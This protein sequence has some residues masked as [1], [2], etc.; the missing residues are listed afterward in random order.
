[1][2]RLNP[3]TGDMDD[4]TR[5]VDR[6]LHS[7]RLDGMDHVERT[8]AETIRRI[9]ARYVFSESDAAEWWTVAAQFLAGRW[10]QTHPQHAEIKEILHLQLQL[11]FQ[12][13]YRPLVLTSLL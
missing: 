5:V 2:L 7:W 4:K 3:E 12:G 6:A 10:H 1:M 9:S 13:H 8:L 11:L